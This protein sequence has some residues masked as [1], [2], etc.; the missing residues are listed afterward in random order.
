[1]E[2]NLDENLRIMLKVSQLYYQDNLTQQEIAENLRISRPKVSRLLQQAREQNIVQ[3]CINAPTDDYT[4]LET[5]LEK[6]YGLKEVFVTYVHNTNSTEE[7][8]RELGRAAAKHLHRLIQDGDLIGF[9]WGGTLSAMVDSI[10][11]ESKENIQTLQLVGGLGDPAAGINV[12]DIV[13]RAAITLNATLV[14][15]PAPGIVETVE[16]HKI[17]MSDRSIKLALDMAPKA[18]IAYAG[19]GAPSLDSIIVTGNIMSQEEM[20]H[21]I[22]QGA[23]GDIGLRFFDI[24]GNPILSDVQNR[25]IGANLATFHKIPCTVG[26]AGGQEK[27]NAILGAIRGKYINTLITDNNTA[28]LLL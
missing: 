21:V 10:M 14:L 26:I 13:R 23:V 11:P 24:Q 1:M 16:A 6:K 2:R 5:K 15:L 12:V 28:Q 20:Q 9:T 7:I 17:L 8:M 27:L 22:D 3:I 4:E 18:D 25:V 19:I